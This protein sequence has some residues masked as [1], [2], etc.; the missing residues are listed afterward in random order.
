MTFVFLFVE[1]CNQILRLINIGDNVTVSIP[2]V[3]RG[4]WERRNIMFVIVDYNDDT[5]MYKLAT[6]GGC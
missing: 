5:N 6:H 1:N 2:S 4:R 3:D